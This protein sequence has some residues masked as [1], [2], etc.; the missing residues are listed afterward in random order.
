VQVHL[1]DEEDEDEGDDDAAAVQLPFPGL[2]EHDENEDC[3]DEVIGSFLLDT[4][5]LEQMTGGLCDAVTRR[6]DGQGMLETLERENVFVVPLDDEWRSYRYHHLFADAL[7]AR[8]AARDADRVGELH[9]AASRWL[10]ENGLLGDAVRH[11]IASG[12]PEHAAELVELTLAD[13]RRRRQDRTLRDWL[14][15]LPDDV[16]RRRPLLAMGRS[17]ARLSP[18]G[19]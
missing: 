18:S 9:A 19:S 14:V 10:G 17:A 5:V 2:A 4:S 6:S 13:M 12:D 3:V 1:G 16:V 8:L 15:A 7:R 11:A